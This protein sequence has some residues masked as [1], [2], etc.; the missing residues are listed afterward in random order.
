MQSEKMMGLGTLTCLIFRQQLD[1]IFGFVMLFVRATMF[2]HVTFVR[3]LMELYLLY[4]SYISIID[5]ELL[6]GSLLRLGKMGFSQN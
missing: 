6:I 3:L 1:I 5:I 4:Q 2:T